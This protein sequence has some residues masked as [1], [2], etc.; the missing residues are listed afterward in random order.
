[1]LYLFTT[2]VHTGALGALLTFSTV[3]WYPAYAA[4]T[5]LLGFDLL[6]D[7][8]LGGLIM[9]VPAGLAYL[10]VALA[11]AARLLQGDQPARASGAMPP[12]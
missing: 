2:M 6:E 12:P 11:A 5:P 8:R 3:P 10:A 7:Q 9:W 4:S 1:M